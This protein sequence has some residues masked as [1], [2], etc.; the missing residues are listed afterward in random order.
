MIAKSSQPGFESLRHD[1]RQACG[2]SELRGVDSRYGLN[3]V[4]HR[5]KLTFLAF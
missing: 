3:K 1:D 5:Q 4:W 2:V